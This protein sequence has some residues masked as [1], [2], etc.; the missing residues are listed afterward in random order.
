M[1][2]LT[3]YSVHGII[4]SVAWEVEF[5]DEFETWWNDL[6]EAEQIKIDAEVRMLEAYGPNLPYPR[7]SGLIGTWKN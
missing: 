3:E 6:T 2:P 5:T 4:E 1:M 7:S